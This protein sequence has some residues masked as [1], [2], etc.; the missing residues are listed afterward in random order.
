MYYICISNCKVE[1]QCTN[2]PICHSGTLHRVILTGVTIYIT[3][4]L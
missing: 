1:L 3:I 2:H 4:L